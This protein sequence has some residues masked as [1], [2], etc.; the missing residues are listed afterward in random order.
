MRRTIDI[1]TIS[2]LHN[3]RRKSLSQE[4]RLHCGC[5]VLLAVALA[6]VPV[7][8]GL[9]Q[10]PPPPQQKLITLALIP[11]REQVRRRKLEAARLN[12]RWLGDDIPSG[13]HRVSRRRRTQAQVLDALYQGYGTHYVDL[14]CGTPTVQRQTVIVD[15]GSGVTAFP[16]LGCEGCGDDGHHTDSLFNQTASKSFHALTCAECQRGHCESGSTDGDCRIGMSYQEGS[17]WSAFE[18]LDICYAG[19]AHDHPLA[20]STTEADS[21]T[22]PKTSKD[23]ADLSVASSFAF[24]MTFGCQTHL[25]GLFRT[26][27]ADGIMGMDNADTAFWSQMHKAGKIKDKLFSLCF[28]RQD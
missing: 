9:Q 4:Q 8:S 18:A 27:L 23:D 5:M 26:Q 28:S 21:A 20:V 3:T 1:M 15:T 16:C 10:P 25:T 6:I 14:W 22:P 7:I 2:S 17:S 24:P 12:R 13:I 19:G 11:H